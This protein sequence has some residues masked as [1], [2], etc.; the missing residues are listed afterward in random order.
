MLKNAVSTCFALIIPMSMVLVTSVHANSL[1]RFTDALYDP[2]SD[3]QRQMPSVVLG[4]SDWPPLVDKTLENQGLISQVVEESF[5]QQ[6]LSVMVAFQPWSRVEKSIKTGTL[7]A[8][9]PWRFTPERAQYF[10]YSEPISR[11]R[12][13]FFSLK[14][15]K[16]DWSQWDDIKRYRMAGVDGYSYAIELQAM[17]RAGELDMIRVPEEKRLID[18]LISGRIDVFPAGEDAGKALIQKYAPQ[19][20]DEI[21]IHKKPVSRRPLYLIAPKSSYGLSLIQA[22]NRGLRSLKASGRYVEI[23]QSEHGRLAA[24]AD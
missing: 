14:N 10:Y 18:L 9:Y 23:Y 24:K 12:N 2:Y 22:F 7:D 1:G 21:V 20:E 16:F 13:V 6:S 3:A 15:T 19:Y 17:D 4:T 11:G 5:Q 8:S